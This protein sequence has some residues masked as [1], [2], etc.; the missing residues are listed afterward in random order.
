[1]RILLDPD[2]WG[3]TGGAFF[4]TLVLAIDF[5]RSGTYALSM[6]VVIGAALTFVVSYLA[7]GLFVFYLHLL[8]EREQAAADD[9]RRRGLEMTLDSAAAPAAGQT[10]EGPRS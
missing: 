5:L 3:L 8:R 6:S 10:E 9:L 2:L 4:A 7:I 1:M